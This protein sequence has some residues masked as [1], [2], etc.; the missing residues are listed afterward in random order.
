M[1][2]PLGPTL[3]NVFLCHFEEQWTSDSPIDYEHISYRRYVDNVFLLFSFE[4]HRTKLLNFMNSK[5]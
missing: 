1:N 2:S 3:S 5:H 4:L